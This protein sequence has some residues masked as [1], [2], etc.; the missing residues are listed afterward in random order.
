MGE[1][2]APGSGLLGIMAYSGAIPPKQDM[3]S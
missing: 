3:D 2:K 1:T